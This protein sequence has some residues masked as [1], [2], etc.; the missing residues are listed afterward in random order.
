[1]QWF[2]C[3]AFAALAINSHS[4]A[5]RE[6]SQLEFLH[7]SKIAK[8][9]YPL[10][11]SRLLRERVTSGQAFLCAETD[12]AVRLK[13]GGCLLDLMPHSLGHTPLS[14]PLAF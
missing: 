1:M 7:G 6:Y 12:P 8:P 13:L 3:R 4:S 9:L 11:P 10:L 14:L 5:S 2:Y